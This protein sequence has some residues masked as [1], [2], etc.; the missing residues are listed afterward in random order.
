[1][2]IW[3]GISLAPVRCFEKQILQTLFSDFFSIILWPVT[4]ATF[5]L[6]FR[7]LQSVGEKILQSYYTN[8]QTP[9]AKGKTSFLKDQPELF[10]LSIHNLTYQADLSVAICILS[11]V[12]NVIFPT[13]DSYCRCIPCIW[14]DPFLAYRHRRVK[15][16]Q[17][18]PFSWG[19]G[20]ETHRRSDCSGESRADVHRVA[21]MGMRWPIYMVSSPLIQ[22]IF[23]QMNHIKMLVSNLTRA[24]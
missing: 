1:M 24:V 16:G 2:S 13:S 5:H 21:A 9:P 3:P 6:P 15:G 4:E 19:S 14:I 17:P 12:E 8:N 18:A 20:P 22:L 7:S 10:I 23:S 11:D